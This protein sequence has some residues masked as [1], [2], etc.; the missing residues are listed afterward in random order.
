[1]IDYTGAF[2][3]IAGKRDLAD[4]IVHAWGTV[5]RT[6]PALPG[7]RA[8]NTSKFKHYHHR[9]TQL[10]NAM[11]NKLKSKGFSASVR[12]VDLAPARR[13]DAME[14]I[15]TNLAKNKHLSPAD[16]HGVMRMMIQHTRRP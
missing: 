5:A 8:A 16:K 13:Q 2:E 1:M 4:S 11:D 7:T 14:V 12:E 15:R 9:L 3:K 10:E 6:T